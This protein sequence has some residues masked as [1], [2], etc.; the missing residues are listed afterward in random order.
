MA[1]IY[2]N[3]KLSVGV[4]EFDNQHKRLIL[5]VNTLHEAMTVGKGKEVIGKV[6]GDLISYTA[7]H[8]A[9]EERFMQQHSYQGFAAHKAEHDQLVKK[10]KALQRDFQEGKLTVAIALST[11]LKEWLTHH[12][13]ESD[14]KYA[15]CVEPATVIH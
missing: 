10:A 12:I 9:A 2:W 1:L 13:M 8:F 15:V 14:K 5:L 6:L 7:T 3:D 11:F 4:E